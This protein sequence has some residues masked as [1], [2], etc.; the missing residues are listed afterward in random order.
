M[1]MQ[2]ITSNGIQTI[3]MLRSQ[4]M[5]PEGEVSRSPR[6]DI[7]SDTHSIVEDGVV[8]HLPQQTR[9]GEAV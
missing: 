2:H 9:Q 1:A 6:E 3:H 5:A 8:P 7:S 4:S